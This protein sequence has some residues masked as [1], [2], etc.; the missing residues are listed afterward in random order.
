MHNTL[1]IL[2]LA[3]SVLAGQ[4]RLDPRQVRDWQQ[5]RPLLHLGVTGATPSPEPTATRLDVHQL[6]IAESTL[7]AWR[8]IVVTGAFDHY[9]IAFSNQ[10]DPILITCSRPA[11][12]PTGPGCVG[13]RFWFAW[14]SSAPGVALIWEL[15]THPR[16]T[17]VQ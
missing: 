12:D 3:A 9:N 6:A 10:P 15:L 17:P 13:G 8:G 16:P 5:V 2:L 7:A 4:T 14:P 11:T 1:Y